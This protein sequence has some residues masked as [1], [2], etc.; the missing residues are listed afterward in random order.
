[1]MG[2]L[3]A[4][5][6][7][8]IG[9]TMDPEHAEPLILPEDTFP[10]CHHE[11]YPLTFEEMP[12]CTLTESANARCPKFR[13]LCD[14]GPVAESFGSGR[15][16]SRRAADASDSG[17]SRTLGS[18]R[19]PREFSW[20]QLGGV[21]QLLFW[22]V[23]AMGIAAVVA[24]ILQSTLRIRSSGKR[25][26]PAA[27]TEATPAIETTD[28]GLPEPLI[29]AT[30][31]ELLTLAEQAAAAGDYGRAVNLTAFALL[32]ELDHRGKVRLH[33]SRTYGD[34][35]RELRNEPDLGRRVATVLREVE[36]AQF[37]SGG[38]TASAFAQIFAQARTL[39]LLTLLALVGASVTACISGKRWP[40]STSPSGTEGMIARMADY[41]LTVRYRSASLSKITQSYGDDADPASD[42]AIIVVLP[43]AHLDDD[44]WTELR[45]WVEQGGMAVLTGSDRPPWS[46]LPIP[47]TGPNRVPV[48]TIV[49]DDSGLSTQL[50]LPSDRALSR[51]DDAFAFAHRGDLPYA[52]SHSFGLGTVLVLA[53]GDLFT[54]AAMMF[55]DNEKFLAW[56]LGWTD[57]EGTAIQLVDQVVGGDAA[58]TPFAAVVRSELGPAMLHLLVWMVVLLLARGARLGSPRDP[59][60]ERR[61]AFVD[62]ARAMGLA[63][64]R[65]GSAEFAGSLYRSWALDRLRR[66]LRRDRP[67]SLLALAQALAGRTGRDETELMRLLLE[68]D[69]PSPSQSI[70]DRGGTT[71]NSREA[72]TRAR[73]LAQ[74]MHQIRGGT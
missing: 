6:L 48:T 72:L 2:V 17:S 59:P 70:L 15:L 36:R 26:K 14:K 46:G 60:Q 65:A 35:V 8:S 61:R 66:T 69:E 43:D 4:L 49:L 23:F 67:P 54:N 37:R 30:A 45:R 24:A 5:V 58:E 3:F 55:A 56:L 51:D 38:A 31:L 29:G 73:E 34:Y 71:P 1:M 25:S 18:E 33:R 62:H 10:F 52:S 13:T 32:R 20:P 42:A 19:T 64:A 68:A 40:G 39:V 16:A 21:A 63:Y 53:D 22:L 74:L 28:T 12:W 11:D 44:E 41:G 27:S 50:S 47:V 7:G 9:A 57:D